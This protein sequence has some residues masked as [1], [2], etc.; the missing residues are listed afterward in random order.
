MIISDLNHLEVVSEASSVVGGGTYKFAKF[1]IDITKQS[2]IS[3][4]NQNAE[5]AAL[6]VKGDAKATAS[7]TAVVFQS[8]S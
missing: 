5:A 2:N 6:S 4:I 7:N 3:V 1:D 8:N